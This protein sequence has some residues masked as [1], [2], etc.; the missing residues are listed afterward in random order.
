MKKIISLLLIIE[1]LCGSIMPIEAAT[2]VSFYNKLCP[3]IGYGWENEDFPTYK[4]VECETKSGEIYASD[5]CTITNVYINSSG[6]WVCKVKYPL[7]SG[8]TKTA[9]AK[10]GRFIKDPTY[11]YQT[12]VANKTVKTATISTK[13]ASSSNTIAEN[14]TFYVVRIDGSKAQVLYKSSEGY[15][16]GWINNY[17]VKF[18]ANGG[19]GGPSSITKVEGETKQ[20][21]TTIPTKKGYTFKGWNLEKDGSSSSYKAGGNIGKNSSVTLYA[22]WEATKYSIDYTYNGG[23]ANNPNPTSYYITTS[24]FTLNNPSKT[25]YTFTGWTGSN[26]STPS[27]SVTISK[28]S[29]GNKTYTA[30]YTINSYNVNTNVLINDSTY[31]GTGSVTGGG[32]YNYNSNVSLKAIPDTECHFVEWSDGNTSNPRTINVKGNCNYTAKFKKN[33]YTITVKANDSSMGTTTGTGTYDYGSKVT[34]AADEGALYEFVNWD[35]GTLG[36]FRDI[37]V[38]GNKTYIAN[39]QISKDKCRHQYG[40]WITEKEATCTDAGSHYKICS[41]CNKRVDEEI[42]PTGHSLGEYI[43][44]KNAAC[45]EKGEKHRE[46]ENCDYIEGPIEVPALDHS[47]EWQITTAPTCTEK[48]IKKM[49]CVACGKTLEIS[50]TEVDEVEHSYEWVIDKEATCLREGHQY[51]QCRVCNAKSTEDENEDNIIPATGHSFVEISDTPPQNG[52]NGE[53]KFECSR[54]SYSY[55]EYYH[56]TI[57]EGVIKVEDTQADIGGTVSVPIRIESNPGFCAFNICIN[58]DRDI[59]K[60]KLVEKG[61][62]IND[63]KGTLSSNETEIAIHQN[64]DFHVEYARVGKNITDDG[65]LFVITFDVIGSSKPGDYEIEVICSGK[66]PDKTNYND[67]TG[68]IETISEIYYN[69]T[70]NNNDWIEPACETGTVTTSI[71]FLIGDANCDLQVNS[72]DVIYIMKHRLEWKD[73]YWTEIHE[74]AA[75]VHHDNVINVKDSNRLMMLLANKD[76]VNEVSQLDN[77]SLMSDE[78]SIININIGTTSAA[79]GDYVYIPVYATHNEGISSFEFQLSF[80][81]NKLL[82]VEVSSNSLSGVLSNLE[83]YDNPSDE[84]P[85]D[86]NF[87]TLNIC[88]SNSE[89][90]TGDLTLFTIKCLV[91][92]N[93]QNGDSITIA[94]TRSD[95]F[96]ITEDNSIA[97]VS[98]TVTNGKV[99]VFENTFPY[100]FENVVIKNETGEILTDIPHE[101]F[102]LCVKLKCSSDVF[103]TCCLIVAAYDKDDKVIGLSSTEITSDIIKDT[104]DVNEDNTVNNIS[105]MK[106]FLWDSLNTM[107]PLS[108]SYQ[109]G[110]NYIYNITSVKFKD[111]NGV[112]Y[113]SLPTDKAVD[114]V[115]EIVGDSDTSPT[116]IVAAYGAEGNLIKLNS[117]NIIEWKSNIGTVNLTLDK[118]NGVSETKVFLWDSLN[119]LKPLSKVYITR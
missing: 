58:Y 105:Y 76:V 33:Q 94:A 97:D 81:K 88:W 44:D 37:T 67:E 39:F 111:K 92:E 25:G 64:L 11:N 3:I 27:K 36:R 10:F 61:E 53:K 17:T 62:L 57:Q 103:Y 84:I 20:L 102:D 80:D 90:I 41:L 40:E 28:G 34:I 89:N 55:T 32:K 74:Q 54:C 70:N 43:I 72:M 6:K 13:S 38:T 2:G 71:K 8:G 91:N 52:A 48:G 50:A 117:T 35:D 109:V 47:Y 87:T 86:E 79:A 26:G 5:K 18:D 65:T 21:P 75:D 24:N 100:A 99:T 82:P 116:I 66:A 112:N 85:D 115:V 107:K 30:N 56:N 12:I 45:T 42:Q 60:P 104:I 63:T 22:Q 14:S 51:K 110:N 1:I 118:M 73:L 4:T 59:L 49:I 108:N 83:Q 68:E 93:A 16:I 31:N 19:S 46:C 95:V 23:F 29:T 98:P 106:L 101:K 15:K 119:A 69:I 9:Y 78:N 7:D 113:D 77:I 114:A 96:T